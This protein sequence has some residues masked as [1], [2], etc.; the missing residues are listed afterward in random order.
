MA[1]LFRTVKSVEAESLERN[2]KIKRKLVGRA[3]VF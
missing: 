3:L 2:G 1:N